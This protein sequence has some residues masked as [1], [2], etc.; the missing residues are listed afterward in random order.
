MMEDLEDLV[1]QQQAPDIIVLTETKRRKH[2]KLYGSMKKTYVVRDCHTRSGN[3]GVAT[4]VKRQYHTTQALT[5]HPVPEPCL[6]YMSH[7]TIAPMHGK[8]LHVIGVYMPID[9]EHVQHRATVY[10]AL[11]GILED[12]DPLDTIV[13]TG[14]WNAALVGTDRLTPL[15]TIDKAHA[16]WV[17]TQQR[18]ES[19]YSVRHSRAV[20]YTKDGMGSSPSMIDDTLVRV[21]PGTPNVTAGADIILHHGYH[22]D[23]ALLTLALLPGKIG[24]PIPADTPVPRPAPSRRLATPVTSRDKD[25]FQLRLA[26]D[27][28]GP[29][30]ELTELLASA[31]AAADRFEQ[32]R[33]ATEA[34]H[35]LQLAELNGLP[36]REVINSLAYKLTSLIERGNDLA[37]ATCTTTITNPTGIHHAPKAKCK[38]RKRHLRTIKTSRRLA[39]QLKNSGDDALSEV[40]AFIAQQLE[41]EAAKAGAQ[42]QAAHPAGGAPREAPSSPKQQQPRQQQL[43]QGRP[44]EDPPAGDHDSGQPEEGELLAQQLAGVCTRAIA[45]KCALEK[46]HRTLN[47]QHAARHVNMLFQKAP[48][49]AHALTFGSGEPK[50]Q[51]TTVIDPATGSPTQAAEK[52][53][54]VLEDFH[55]PLLRPPGGVKNGKYLPEEAPRNYP[56]SDKSKEGL[57]P[58]KL[59]TDATGTNSTRRWLAD[60]IRDE[61][62]FFAYYKTLSS[63]KAPG[64]DKVTN[65]LLKILPVAVKKLI[66]QLFIVMWATGLT[67][68]AWKESETCMIHKKGN[69]MVIGNY[70]PIGLANTIYKLWT[71]MVTHILYEHAEENRIISGAQSGFRKNTGTHMPLQML[72]MAIEDARATGQDLYVMLVDFSSAFNMTDHDKTLMLMYDLGYPTDAVEVVKDIYSGATTRYKTAHGATTDMAVDRGTLQGDTLSPFLFSLYIEPLLRWLRVG[73]RGYMFGSVKQGRAGAPGIRLQQPGLC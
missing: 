26:A 9:D 69:P 53:K 34:T 22:T 68:D 40:R 65:E 32:E 60:H 51:L 33:A 30:M 44:N 64:P 24:V 50:Q 29:I 18:L 5:Q 41:Q 23:H 54:Q 21:A 3:A 62:V 7:I 57:D 66:H 37:L 70:R 6:G 43:R 12:T 59:E 4:L 17:Q 58:F 49:K 73:S 31:A 55:R 1:L 47:R 52:V 56:W 20:T 16:Q 27:E 48:K 28:S 72:V 61:Q 42:A 19:V 38:L 39:H 63:G 15:T 25:A 11:A 36:A 10:Q 46:Q 2:L 67:P 14:D 8:R 45:D 71:R 13:L 35:T